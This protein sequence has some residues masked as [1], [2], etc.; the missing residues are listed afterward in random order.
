MTDIYSIFYGKDALLALD[1]RKKVKECSSQLLKL[2][3]LKELHD[4]IVFDE[5]FELISGQID[6]DTGWRPICVVF[7]P[8]GVKAD[9]VVCGDENGYRLIFWEHDINAQCFEV[10]RVSLLFS[11]MREGVAIHRLFF[12]EGKAVDYVIEGMNESFAEMFGLNRENA[13][14][15]MASSL[16]EA[17]K[18]PFLRKF[19]R[20]VKSA[21]PSQ[22]DAFNARLSRHYLISVT[23]WDECRFGTVVSD[24]SQSRYSQ[25]LYKALNEA[26]AD[27]SNIVETDE[28]FDGTAKVLQKNG[29]ECMLLLLDSSALTTGIYQSF[30]EPRYLKHTEQTNFIGGICGKAVRER[31]SAYIDNLDMREILQKAGFDDGLKCIASPLIVSGELKGI[32]VILSRGL[33]QRDID[34]VTAF[35]NQLA[36]IMEKAALIKDLRAHIVKLEMSRKAHKDAAERLKL[37]SSASRVGIW[38]IDLIRKVEYMDTTLEKIYG[39]EPGTFDGKIESWR[40][41]VHADDIEN[42]IKAYKKALGGGDEYSVEFRIILNDG[43]VRHISSAGMLHKD[44]GGKPV[45]MVGTDWDITERKKAELA[46][47]AEKELMGATLRSI[48][49]GVVVTDRYA[50]ITL[51]NAQFE[52]IIGL[53]RA[54]IHGCL[55][56]EVVK[57]I[58]GGSGDSDGLRLIEK[59]LRTGRIYSYSGRELLRSDGKIVPV[60][61]TAAPIKDSGSDICGS[62]IVIRDITEEKKKQDKIDY[63][64]YHDSLTGVYNRRYFE[65]MLRKYDTKESLPISILSCDV[66]G[67]K[68]TNDAF[69]H[70][71]GDRLLQRMAA[72]MEKA[73]RPE[74]TVARIGGDEFYILMPNADEKKAKRTCEKVKELAASNNRFEIDSSVS[75]GFETKY[76]PDQNINTIIKRAESKMYRIK[77]FEDPDRR[78]NSINTILLTLHQRRPYEQLHARQVSDICGKIACQMGLSKREIS[79]IKAAGLMHDIGKIA[80]PETIFNKPGK[81]TDEEWT[82]VKRHCE[83]GFRIISGS[84]DMA[85]IARTVL[86]HHERFDG[87]G[88]PSGIAGEDIPLKARILAVADTYDAMINERPY[89]KPF[90]KRAAL[91][92]I[93]ALSGAQ[94]DPK[95]VEAFLKLME[96]DSDEK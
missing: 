31:C 74:D 9:G 34:A 32:F 81:L 47:T 15:K 60:A 90:S 21:Q 33:K 89:R 40:K 44:D 68:L 82:E 77:T 52:Q 95:V 56:G 57:T 94:F 18:A 48:G 63:L 69:G 8:T 83:I 22:F 23:P 30:G 37:A 4:G 58:D 84:I 59:T 46:L 79:E 24:L 66:N 96:N 26:A 43:S 39:I 92:E 10:A 38:D 19:A 1:S 86:A 55:F 36:A 76:R 93:A 87:K 67:L 3:G 13:E 54:Q 29:F 50:R 80:V 85:H 73:A 42:V 62:V 78:D 11:H 20:V 12:K 49:D 65:M 25:M 91:K 17:G 27:I 71:A 35:A 41:F 75:I 72:I 7:K 64:L 5:M 88:Y 6:G 2:F 28:L 61:Y 14:G 53:K 70:G 45:R 16:F 51:V